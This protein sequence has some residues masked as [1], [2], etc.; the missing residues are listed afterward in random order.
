MIIYGLVALYGNISLY[1]ELKGL[2]SVYDLISLSISNVVVL[3]GGI[4]ILC[5]RKI[6]ILKAAAIYL[7]SVGAGRTLYYLPN[8]L[9]E[10]I[11]SYI[12]GIVILILSINL[13]VKGI[14]FY[15]G[16][17][18]NILITTVSILVFA[19]L[20]SALLVWQL[21]YSEGHILD[22]ALSEAE[23]IFSIILYLVFLGILDTSEIR[24]KSGNERVD[25][26]INSVK[27]WYCASEKTYISKTEA[28][29]IRN[30][31]SNM[32]G[33]TIIDDQSPVSHEYV[34]TI[35]DDSS[36]SEVTV[37]RWKDSRDLYLTIADSFKGS[38]LFAR[39]FTA[40]RWTIIDDPSDDD[41]SWLYLYDD[42]GSF[43]RF[44][45]V[46]EPIPQGS[47]EAV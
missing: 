10:S 9:S 22:T 28:E 31:F 14:S 36:N 8:L 26:G 45:I 18:R 20:Y 41:N 6:T 44:R 16:N 34:F 24:T 15:K 4:V 32:E 19:L 37:Q 1:I 17:P 21:Y 13:I 7:I 12:F 42:Q 39:R 29:T 35:S 11:Y 25:E 47:E 5:R 46:P 40:T 33:W 23:L 27:R 43:L 2:I 30:G 3:I 38:V